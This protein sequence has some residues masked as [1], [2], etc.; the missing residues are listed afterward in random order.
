M[1]RDR[2]LLSY[3]ELHSRG[4]GFLDNRGCLSEDISD[5]SKSG[6]EDEETDSSFLTLRKRVSSEDDILLNPLVFP[7]YLSLPSLLE[8]SVYGARN[9]GLT[10]D[11]TQ[12]LRT[13]SN[14][15]ANNALGVMHSAVAN[16][17]I[18]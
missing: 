14:Q 10:I 3:S 4:L 2:Q 5:N 1:R 13:R 16:C 12:L 11:P 17:D 18:W 8:Q 7:P 9:V 6:M 15:T